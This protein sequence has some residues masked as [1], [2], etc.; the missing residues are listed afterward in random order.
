MSVNQLQSQLDR[1]RKQRIDAQRKVGDL[2]NKESNL[3]AQADKARHDS[4]KSKIGA[5]QRNKTNEAVRRDKDAAKAGRDAS[6]YQKKFTSYTKEEMRLGDQ[7]TRAEK[8]AA[9]AAKQKF[10][11]DQLK[12]QRQT[13]AQ[14]ADIDAQFK[15]TQSALQDISRELRKPRI[16]KLRILLLGS[17]SE[18]DLRVGR[19]QQRI[20]TAIET[21]L[22]RN[23]IE[24]DARPA[25]TTADLLDGITKFRPH[26]VHF[27]GH[28]SEELIV[29]E[30]DIDGHHIGQTVTA[31]AFKRALTATDDPPLLV[32]LNACN[33]AAKLGELTKEDVPFAIGMSG[34]ITDGDAINYASQLYSSVANGQ[35]ISAAHVGGQ[36]ALE[37]VGLD[38]SELPTLR[39]AEGIDPSN[40][41]LVKPIE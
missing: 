14:Q 41:V 19:E 13:A 20:R 6:M 10:R 3:R 33:S 21:A 39:S 1:K 38:G 26:V 17:S 36:V 15:D 16:E 32:V 8:S 4:L 7:L 25:A 5:T 27:S 34:S 40:T 18:G 30:Q 35:S 28:S 11:R 2:R 22:H 24:I 31:S 12:A 29:F 23:L 37:L 9:A